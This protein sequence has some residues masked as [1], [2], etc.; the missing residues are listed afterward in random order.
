MPT[1]PTPSEPVKPVVEPEEPSEAEVLYGVVVTNV[2]EDAATTLKSNDIIFRIGDVRIESPE[3]LATAARQKV[4]AVILDGR[5]DEEK[6]VVITPT[7][8]GSLG[9]TGEKKRLQ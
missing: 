5:N 1:D 7:K 2:A 4:I 6:P 8:V 9:A 3:D